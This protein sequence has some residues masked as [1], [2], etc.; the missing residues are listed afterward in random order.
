MI[1]FFF[2]SAPVQ[3]FSFRVNPELKVKAAVAAVIS[4]ASWA[5]LT[6]KRSQ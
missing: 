2:W 3:L 1:L 4:I 6:T 5:A